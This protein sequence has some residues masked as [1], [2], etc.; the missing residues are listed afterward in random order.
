MYYYICFLAV[1]LKEKSSC[2]EIKHMSNNRME[3][4]LQNIQTMKQHASVEMNQLK[5]CISTQNISISDSGGRGKSQKNRYHVANTYASSLHP[6]SSP[7][8]KQ[9]W[10][11]VPCRDQCHHKV[12]LRGLYF[13][14]PGFSL[15]HKQPLSLN[16]QMS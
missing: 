7:D 4:K 14:V 3:M 12:T 2:Q 5:R 6:F 16:E 13:S 1:S 10:W 8:C 15:R 9:L 11:T